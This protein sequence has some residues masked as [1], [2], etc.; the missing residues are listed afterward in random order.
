MT[1]LFDI[2]LVNL[3][4]LLPLVF[5]LLVAILPKGEGAQ[6]RSATLIAM[7][8][9]FALSVA[10]YLK[11][12]PA[13]PEFQMEYRARWIDTVGISFHTGVDGLAGWPPR[14]IGSG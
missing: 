9:D 5:S 12:D 6:I 1:G 2:H 13:G 7:L 11:F 10:M 3:V 4:V 8:V 14:A